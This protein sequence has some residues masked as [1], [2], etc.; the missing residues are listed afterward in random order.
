[1]NTV[2][3]K[4]LHRVLHEELQEIKEEI[5]LLRTALE[6]CGLIEPPKTGE[7]E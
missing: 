2:Q 6:K 3:I 5:R 7:E 4:E 1:M